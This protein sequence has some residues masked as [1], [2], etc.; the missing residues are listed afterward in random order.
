MPCEVVAPKADDV[1]SFNAYIER[2][3]AGLPIER[4]AVE[5]VKL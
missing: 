2:F 5:C 4:A 3:K 1:A